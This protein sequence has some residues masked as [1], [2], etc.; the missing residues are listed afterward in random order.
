MFLA[1]EF[2]AAEDKGLRIVHPSVLDVLLDL[3]C[4]H[5]TCSSVLEPQRCSH[6][7]AVQSHLYTPIVK[8]APFAHSAAVNEYNAARS[9]SASPK[10][11]PQPFVAVV[12]VDPSE[13]KWAVFVTATCA[14]GVGFHGVVNSTLRRLFGCSFREGFSFGPPCG[15]HHDR[16]H[17]PPCLPALFVVLRA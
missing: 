11:K 8:A 10:A 1:G 9:N 13:P 12:S 4:A 6:H 3:L 7:A 5:G 2:I 17:A 16:T 14:A 15:T